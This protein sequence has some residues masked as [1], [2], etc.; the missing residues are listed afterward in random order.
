MI[1]TLNQSLSLSLFDFHFLVGSVF[2]S[3]V[4]MFMEIV[5]MCVAMLL[6]DPISI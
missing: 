5:R 4:F 6:I 1:L 3:A 2:A